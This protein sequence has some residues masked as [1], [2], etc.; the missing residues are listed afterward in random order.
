MF[1]RSRDRYHVKSSDVVKYPN[2]ILLSLIRNTF[3]QV[4]YDVY[5]QNNDLCTC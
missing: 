4:E 1:H 2:G 5:Y 3:Y